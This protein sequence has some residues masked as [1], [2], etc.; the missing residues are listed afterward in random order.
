MFWKDSL[1][2]SLIRQKA[3]INYL[4]ENLENIREIKIYME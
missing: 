4:E 1:R 3:A 2:G